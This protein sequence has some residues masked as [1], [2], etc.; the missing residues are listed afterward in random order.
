MSAITTNDVLNL[1]QLSMIQ[2]GDD[3]A[4]RLTHDI[5]E[6]LAYVDML[7]ELNTQGVEPTYQLNNRQN[8]FRPDTVNQGVVTRGELLEL[9]PETLENQVKV[10]K[11]L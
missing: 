9:A 4:E 3:E 7:G 1:A 5:A 11:V 8:V 2:L 10:P 6:I